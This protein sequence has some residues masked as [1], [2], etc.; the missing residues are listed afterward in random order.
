MILVF[1]AFLENVPTFMKIGF[2]HKMTDPNVSFY[3]LDFLSRCVK[4]LGTYDLLYQTTHFLGEQ[5]Y[6]YMSC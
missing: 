2:L 3:F 5:K 4:Q 6:W 1:I